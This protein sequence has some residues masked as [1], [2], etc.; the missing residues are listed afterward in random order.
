MLV[1][2]SLRTDSP[3][4]GMNLR[5]AAH[6]EDGFMLCESNVLLFQS[7][8]MYFFKEFSLAKY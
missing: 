2:F 7:K 6:C 5:D 1:W 3:V 8:Y 4:V